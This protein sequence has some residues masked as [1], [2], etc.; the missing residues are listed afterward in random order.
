M[1]DCKVEDFQRAVQ[2]ANV[3]QPKFFYG[4]TATARGALLRKW[5][6]LIIE[7]REDRMFAK[8]LRYIFD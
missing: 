2:S 7:N 8:Y 5:Y 4:H 1:T 6:D 3:A